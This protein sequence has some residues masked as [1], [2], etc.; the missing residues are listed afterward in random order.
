MSTYLSRWPVALEGPIP[1]Q[2]ILRGTPSARARVMGVH[3]LRVNSV[4]CAALLFPKGAERVRMPP[5]SNEKRK[6]R[7]SGETTQLRWREALSRS[8]CQRL[9]P[10]LTPRRIGAPAWKVLRSDSSGASILTLLQSTARP[11]LGTTERLSTGKRVSPP[12]PASC[13]SLRYT[14]RVRPRTPHGSSR[15][16][17]WSWLSERGRGGEV[18]E[19]S[20]RTRAEHEALMGA[21]S[22]SFDPLRAHC[23]LYSSPT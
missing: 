2:D 10:C 9:T 5:A 4:L 18:D 8:T 7:P 19:Q 6:S 16:A 14:K 13:A 3:V 1:D 21:R 22:A 11:L 12:A 20:T 17:F 23:V 15:N